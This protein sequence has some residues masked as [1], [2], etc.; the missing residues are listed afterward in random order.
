MLHC[1]SVRTR[2]VFEDFKE[3]V[4]YLFDYFGLDRHWEKENRMSQLLGDRRGLAPLSVEDM[5][6]FWVLCEV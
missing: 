1:G 5:T 3:M 4:S 6:R 2:W